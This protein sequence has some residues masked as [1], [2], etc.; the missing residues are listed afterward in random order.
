MVMTMIIVIMMMAM[1]TIKVMMVIK[2]V[3]IVRTVLILQTFIIIMM[4]MMI[5]AMTVLICY[6]IFLGLITVF[7]GPYY[8][9]VSHAIRNTND[10]QGKEKASTDQEPDVCFVC[11]ILRRPVGMT[12]DPRLYRNKPVPA[13]HRRAAENNRRQPYGTD[14]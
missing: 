12:T 7:Y 9:L 3:M 10:S 5:I 11:W 6:I 13:E 14:F 1:M 2:A 8:I 4:M